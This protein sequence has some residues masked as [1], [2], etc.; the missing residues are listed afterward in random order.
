MNTNTAAPKCAEFN[1]DDA[2]RLVGRHGD[3]LAGAIGRVLGSF[4][5]PLETSYPVAFIQPKVTVLD[6][7]PDEIVLVDDFHRAAA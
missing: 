5:R 3:V 7:R 1:L 4:P 2:V 6:L